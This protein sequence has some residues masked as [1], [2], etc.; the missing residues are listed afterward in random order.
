MCV[1][2]LTSRMSNRAINKRAYSVACEHQNICGD[3]PEKTAFKGYA[4]KHERKSQYSNS[5][6]YPWSAFSAQA[7]E[8]TKRVSKTFSL[9]Q[10]Y[11]Y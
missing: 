4:A 5:L 6:A 3:L 9:A 8:V 11:A 10:K 7:P 1:P 2:H